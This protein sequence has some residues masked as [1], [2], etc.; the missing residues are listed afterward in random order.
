MQFKFLPLYCILVYMEQEKLPATCLL[1]GLGFGTVLALAL[2]PQ[3][4][5]EAAAAAIP[6]L[7]LPP[8][9]FAEGAAAT[10]LATVLPP[11]VFA[12]GAAAAV[13]ALALLPVVFA[14]VT[15]ATHEVLHNLYHLCKYGSVGVSTK[16]SFKGLVHTSP[17]VIMRKNADGDLD[18]VWRLHTTHTLFISRN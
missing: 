18:V 14:T 15:V 5:A 17:T 7:A 12:E 13:L 6:A 4:F 11:I 2:L 3:V 10:V 16:S 8:V 9:V 1:L